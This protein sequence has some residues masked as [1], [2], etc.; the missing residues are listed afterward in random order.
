MR[1]TVLGIAVSLGLAA[2]LVPAAD[3]AADRRVHGRGGGRLGAGHQRPPAFHKHGIE[4]HRAF[5]RHFSTLGVFVGAPVVVY[6]PPPVAFSTPFSTAAVYAPPVVFTP[7]PP[8][9][10]SPPVAQPAPM[11]RVVEHPAGRYELRGDG[12]ATPYTW[13]WIPNP[14]PAPRSS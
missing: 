6:T 12:I 13:V 9:L 11:P 8:I 2:I 5:P 1:K 10:G 3:V 4:R 14:P 7:P